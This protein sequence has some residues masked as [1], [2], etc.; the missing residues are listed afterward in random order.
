MKEQI[1]MRR[2]L[3]APAFSRRL[4]KA[5]EDYLGCIFHLVS[6]QVDGWP[7]APGHGSLAFLHVCAQPPLSRG[8][9]WATVY[10]VAKS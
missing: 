5:M 9:W 6:K 4:K 2:L 1:S 3:G 10:G 7:G 8:A